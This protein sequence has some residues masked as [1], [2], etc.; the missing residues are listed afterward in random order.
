MRGV[1]LIEPLCTSIEMWFYLLWSLF[2]VMLV[3]LLWEE[4]LVFDV[5]GCSLTKPFLANCLAMWVL[6]SIFTEVIKSLITSC[7]SWLDERS[8]SNWAIVYLYWDVV[9]PAVESVPCYVGPAFYGLWNVGFRWL[10]GFRGQIVDRNFSTEK[11]KNSLFVQ[12]SINIWNKPTT[13]R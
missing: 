6:D 3:L 2:L 13:S 9:L 5:L 4:P 8:F 10:R 11:K 12:L 1:S 7:P